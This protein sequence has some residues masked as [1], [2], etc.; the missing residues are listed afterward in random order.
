MNPRYIN[1]I[2]ISIC[3]AL[4]GLVVIQ[5]NWVK[6]SYKL[7]ED[8]F[9]QEVS[10]A[11]SN[12]THKLELDEAENYFK[13]AGIPNFQK[14]VSKMYDTM[15]SMRQINENF[16][17]IDSIGQ[18]A[19]KFG[20]SDTTGAFVSRFFGS[21]TY[22]QERA[23]EIQKQALDVTHLSDPK[24]RERKV[25]EQQFVK[26]NRFFEELAVKF[27]LDDKCLSERIDTILLNKLLKNELKNVGV[28]LDYKFALFDDF[29]TEPIVGTLKNISKADVEQYYSIPLYANDFYRNSG[30]LVVS[31]PHKTN[32]ILQSMWLMIAT[33][34][35]FIL[36]ILTSFGA[37][38]F[39]IFRQKKI[40][41]LKNDF[42]NNMT[43]EFKTPVATISLASQM[44]KDEDVINNTTRTR[45]YADMIEEENKR[46]SGHI[47]NV[48]QAA[49][50]DRGDFKLKIEKLD[51]HD[52]LEDIV[53]SL[54][55]RVENEGGTITH[56]FN[57]QRWEIQGD[58]FHLTNGVYNIIENA[59]K[60]RKDDAPEIKVSTTSNAKG[61][62]IAVQDNGIGISKENQKMIFEKFYRVPT[63][64]IHNVKGFG[65]GLSY[66]K[67]IVDAHNGTISVNSELGKGS[68]FEVFLP[69]EHTL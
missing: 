3:V 36:I 32:Y 39:I 40:D 19:M 64:N 56:D 7:R 14:T 17:L 12:T 24:E 58:K 6:Q 34:L 18:N 35:A 25:I 41:Q 54:Q 45:R 60:Y 67:I 50:F 62:T 13:S 1:F 5:V 28:D 65:L 37:S 11:M 22:L 48:L 15:Q 49:R 66:V 2:L 29:S 47:E 59:L 52:L 30:L 44:L 21:V 53:S 10:L 57:A 8:R 43:H 4:L 9:D 16:M 31:F 23:E 69:F 27:M 55:F 68:R 38:F 63:G 46:L 26:Y 51:M 42:I 61:I 33:T 20:F